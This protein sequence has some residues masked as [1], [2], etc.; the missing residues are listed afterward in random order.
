MPPCEWRST[1]RTTPCRRTPGG[2]FGCSGWSPDRTSP[3]W[4]RPP[5]PIPN[6]IP[7]GGCW[8]SSS[9]RTWSTRQPRAGTCCT[10][11]CASTPPGGPTRRTVRP[12]GGRPSAGCTTTTCRASMPPGSSCTRRSSG[13]RPT[14]AARS[15]RSGSTTATGR[16]RGW[17]PNGRTW[18]PPS[19]TPA[20]TDPRQ[21]A[22]HLSL[23]LL[24]WCIGRYPQAIEQYNTALALA[25]RAPWVEAEAAVLGNLGATYW[26][27]GDLHGSAEHHTKALA[28]NRRI[29]RPIGEATNLTTLG[30]VYATLGRLDLATE[31]LVEALA[32]GRRLGSYNGGA[33]ATLGE[34]YYQR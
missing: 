19:P 27:V 2:C 31:H 23:G 13:C 5:W 20:N 3:R 15:T 8:P 29:G 28:I 6:P 25:R 7:R 18:S 12:T 10:T 14:R 32:I 4:P 22:A 34:V 1:C 24:D 11:S 26:T 30:V 9:G 16:R 21:V 33:L 17:T